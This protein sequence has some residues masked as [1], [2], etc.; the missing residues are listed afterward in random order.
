M[1]KFSQYAFKIE[2]LGIFVLFC[3]GFTSKA[4]ILN[5]QQVRILIRSNSATSPLCLGPAML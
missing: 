5:V 2:V 3:F 4:S 1:M